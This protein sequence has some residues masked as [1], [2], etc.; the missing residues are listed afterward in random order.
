[1][2]NRL[3][4]LLVAL[5]LTSIVQLY[6]QEQEKEKAVNVYSEDATAVRSRISIVQLSRNFMKLFNEKFPNRI[7][8]YE[9]TVIFYFVIDA[10]GTASHIEVIRSDFNEEYTIHFLQFIDKVTMNAWIPASVNGKQVQKD[11]T[12]KVRVGE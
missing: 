5:S 11:Y 2:R 12:L 8:P 9:R 7:V 4:S 3:L 6:G 10:D 1:M